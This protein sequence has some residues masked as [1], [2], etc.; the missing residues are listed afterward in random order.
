MKR[1]D[2]NFKDEALKLSDDIGIKKACEQLNLNYGTLAGRR[3]RR[4]KKRRFIYLYYIVIG[5]ANNDTGK[6]RRE[7]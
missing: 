3:K 4:V 6:K 5:V 7:T 2:Q 1:Y